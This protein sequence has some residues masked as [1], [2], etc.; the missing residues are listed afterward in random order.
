MI[1]AQ[2]YPLAPTTIIMPAAANGPITAPRPYNVTSCDA[3]ALT[4]SGSIQSLVYAA[5][6]E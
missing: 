5:A 6:I 3:A 1:A 2:K 4:C